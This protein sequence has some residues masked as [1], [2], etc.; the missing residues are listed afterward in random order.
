MKKALIILVLLFFFTEQ[1]FA[2]VG[3]GVG[4]GKIQV[5]QKLN[6]GTIYNLPSITVVNTGD[7]SMDYEVG[8]EHHENQPQLIP[9]ENWF[10]FSPSKFHLNPKKVQKVNI[11]LNLPI[12][13]RPGDYFAYLEARPV[14]K[15][16]SGSTSVNIAAATKLYFTVVPGSAIAGVYYKIISL[17]KELSPWPQIIITAIILCV[18]LVLIRRFVNV[19]IKLVKQGVPKWVIALSLVIFFIAYLI[20]WLKFFQII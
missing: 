8:I 18:S 20:F 13:A 14:K 17:W 7:V 3:V 2:K 5:D 16:T 4:V 6:P 15:T 12:N 10:S 11:T 9:E 1:A 19:E